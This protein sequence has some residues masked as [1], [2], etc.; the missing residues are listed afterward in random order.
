MRMNFPLKALAV[1]GLALL[2]LIPL[3]LTL[4]L[5]EGRNHRQMETEQQVARL[6]A[7]PQTLIGP[8]LVVPYTMDVRRLEGQSEAGGVR[9]VWVEQS[10]EHRLV[11]RD[12]EL[13]GT[14]QIEA[15]R[16]GLYRTQVY[17]LN[18]PLVGSFD[19][20]AQA[21]LPSGRNL[22][23]GEPFLVLGL[24]DPRGIQNR[25]VITLE[26]RVWPFQAGSRQAH[27]AKGIHAPL[28][29]LGLSMARTLS[30][31][32]DLELMGTRS[33]Q[34]APVAGETRV[35][36]RGSWPAPSFEGGFAPVERSWSSAGFQAQWKVPHL[37]RDLE[38]LLRGG[39]V[40]TSQHFGVAFLDPVNLYL[41]SE[42]AAKYGFLFVLLTFGAFLLR[43]RLK[44]EPIHM[45]QYLLVG[46][47]LALF[48]L[49]LLSLA[50]H[51]G[52]GRAYLA[53]AAANLSLLGTYLTGALKGRREGAWFTGGLALLYGALYGLLASEDN[54]LLLGSSLLFLLLAG[55]MVGTR[56]LDWQRSE[57]T[58]IP[59][60]ASLLQP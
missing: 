52:F 20:P 6:T 10:F 13:V 49:L 8:L 7:T 21:G 4:G 16:R 34:L 27:P 15:R 40:G 44:G 50:E 25:M 32:I 9:E 41:L 37:S 36:L 59:P 11:P 3:A 57:R 5:V 58:P 39:E 19:L 24:A 12:L 43:E 48:F 54:A 45:I 2:L 38:Q 22:K 30:F 1:G 53:A 29:G 46:A 28:P 18:G 23:I 14:V 33:F 17:R 47:A 55:V 56:K 31:R 60:P 35:S 26:G 42:R 51:I